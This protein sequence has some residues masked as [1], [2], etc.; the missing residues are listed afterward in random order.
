MTQSIA[1]KRLVH[2]VPFIMAAIGY[3]WQGW[4]QLDLFLTVFTACLAAGYAGAHITL[5]VNEKAL[6]LVFV[7]AAICMAGL[8]LYR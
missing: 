2:A 1:T 6:K 4:L 7:G 8:I 5:K 3:F